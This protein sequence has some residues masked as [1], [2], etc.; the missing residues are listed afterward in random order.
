MTTYKDSG[1]VGVTSPAVVLEMKSGDAIEFIDTGSLQSGPCPETPLH[2]GTG[3][4]CTN[5]PAGC[6]DFL[7]DDGRHVVYSVAEILSWSDGNTSSIQPG[8]ERLVITLLALVAKLSLHLAPP[9]A[10]Q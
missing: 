7:L 6:L 4:G 3:I 5:P 9:P 10:Q 1:R 8:D 2:V